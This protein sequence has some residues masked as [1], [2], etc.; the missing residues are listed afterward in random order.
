MT[1]NNISQEVAEEVL[2]EPLPPAEAEVVQETPPP[3]DTTEAPPTEPTET[4]EPSPEASTTFQLPEELKTAPQP[5]QGLTDFEKQRLADYDS[6]AN[7]LQ[8]VEQQQEIDKQSQQLR[9]HYEG[10]GWDTTAAEAMANIHKVEREQSLQQLTA[11][12]GQIDLDKAKNNA[13]NF[14]GKQE[15]VDPSALI[16]FNSPEEMEAYAKLLAHTGKQEKRLAALEQGK[17]KEQ[18][19]DSGGT[20]AGGPLTDAEFMASDF[21]MTPANIERGNKILGIGRAPN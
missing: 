10:Q 16:R 14:Y 9:T 21:E 11:M 12:Q 3:A 5:Q 19:Y 13:A 20:V 2:N 18:S 1:I 15:G 6:R 17:V 8:A 4:P 7:R